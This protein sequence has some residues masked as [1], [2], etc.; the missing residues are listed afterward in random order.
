MI[1]MCSRSQYPRTSF[2]FHEQFDD[3]KNSATTIK[4]NEKLD[5][6]LSTR[7]VTSGEKAADSNS[8]VDE[9]IQSPSGSHGQFL[10]DI[11]KVDSPDP[12]FSFDST[13]KTSEHTDHPADA[14][15][16]SKEISAK[17]E[18]ELNTGI[19]EQVAVAPP[20][21]SRQTEEVQNENILTNVSAAEND[22]KQGDGVSVDHC[23]KIEHE[24]PAVNALVNQ[25]E[26]AFMTEV[27]D[28]LNVLH[29]F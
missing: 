10:E 23:P 6:H 18:H 17:L 13:I 9:L 24:L 1:Y 25:D 5:I 8:S 26:D 20:V 7:V 16:C 15:T 19:R 27:S 3:S 2:E 29:H 11:V 22:L 14:L 28:G 12:N 21:V 4:G